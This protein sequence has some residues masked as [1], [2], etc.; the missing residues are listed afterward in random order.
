[1]EEETDA[2]LSLLLCISL[3]QGNI[4]G[5]KAADMFPCVFAC[6]KT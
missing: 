1:V 5:R 2:F 6:G 4:M 3:L